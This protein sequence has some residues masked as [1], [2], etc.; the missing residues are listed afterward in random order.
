MTATSQADRITIVYELDLSGATR[1]LTVTVELL[2]QALS[3]PFV[4]DLSAVDTPLVERFMGLYNPAD[5]V[6]VVVATT[7]ITVN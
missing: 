7:E 2:F 4:A 3:Y 1:A 6:P 5:N